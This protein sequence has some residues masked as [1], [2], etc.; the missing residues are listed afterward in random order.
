LEIYNE[1][2]FDLLDDKM[3]R[4]LGGGR[5]ARTQAG[6]SL[7][8]VSAWSGGDCAKGLKEIAMANEQEGYAVLEKGFNN[9]WG[10][11]P[12]V[13]EFTQT[14]RFDHTVEQSPL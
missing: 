6:M 4:R 12:G 9:R 8:R 2:I 1:K 7:W 14:G 5:P 13:A 11:R 3:W 10:N